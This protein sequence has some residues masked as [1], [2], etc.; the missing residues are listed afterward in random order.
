[1]R[2]RSATFFSRKH[3]HFSTARGNGLGRN[4]L[5]YC[6][7]LFL[8]CEFQSCWFFLIAYEAI[9]TAL[10]PSFKVKSYFYDAPA[11]HNCKAIPIPERHTNIAGII[12]HDKKCFARYEKPLKY[13]P[14]VVAKKYVERYSS[15]NAI[16]QNPEERA[17]MNITH[18]RDRLGFKCKQNT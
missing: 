12:I 2:T 4:L 16:A 13:H 7:W 1:M 18:K 17:Q 5:V 10:R 6:W 3:I 15:S 14:L 11:S 9:L 8:R